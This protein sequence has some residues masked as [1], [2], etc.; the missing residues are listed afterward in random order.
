M[1]KP[2]KQPP[3]PILARGHKSNKNLTVEEKTIITTLYASGKKPKEISEIMEIPSRTVRRTVKKLKDGQ[4]LENKMK[5]N[6][7]RKPAVNWLRNGIE[8]TTL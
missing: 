7:G 5:G 1:T 4:S 3:L 8:K 2:K 6:C